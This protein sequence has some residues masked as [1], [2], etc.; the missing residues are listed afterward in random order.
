MN[1]LN[2]KCL[3]K[4][5]QRQLFVDLI[6]L[7]KNL[8]KCN[9]S[10]L[11]AFIIIHIMCAFLF[12]VLDSFFVVLILFYF[13]LCRLL[14]LFNP[15]TCLLLCFAYI[16]VISFWSVLFF[17]LFLPLRAFFSNLPTFSHF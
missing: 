8:M 13:T 12:S 6:F 7:R 4:C 5:L 14:F 9:Y 17:S 11:C 2:S 10:L 3:L 1:V 15:L 16:H